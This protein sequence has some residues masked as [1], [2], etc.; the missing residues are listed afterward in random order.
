MQ[1]QGAVG[2][3]PQVLRQ[4]AWATVQVPEEDEQLGRQIF[5]GQP[6]PFSV[7]LTQAK[8]DSQSA[9]VVQDGES[10]LPT[11]MSTQTVVPSALWPQKQPGLVAEQVLDVPLQKLAPATQ[12]FVTLTHV[13]LWQV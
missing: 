10:Q 11:E 6:H 9:L 13:P 7:T 4:L 1:A 5:V 3:D 2:S 12:V 8:P